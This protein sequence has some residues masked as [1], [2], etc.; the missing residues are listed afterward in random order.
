MSEQRI[1]ELGIDADRLLKR[2]LYLEK[3]AARSRFGSNA[4][5]KLDAEV[6]QL[7]ARAKQLHEDI[8]RLARGD[9]A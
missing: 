4:R 8:S 6:L 3:R 1:R 9:V 2:A 5:S 7:R